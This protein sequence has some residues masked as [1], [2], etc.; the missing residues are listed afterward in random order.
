MNNNDLFL[1]H[2]EYE[3]QNRAF[4]LLS[5]DKARFETKNTEFHQFWSTYFELEKLNQLK[6]KPYAEKYQIKMDAGFS[7]RVKLYFASLSM[8]LFPTFVLNAMTDATIKY[9]EKL[10]TLKELSPPEDSTFFDY[11]IRQERV[12]AEALTLLN[13]GAII[14]AEISIRKFIDANS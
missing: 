13:S 10:E 9:V 3:V 14:E 11:V 6:Y 8:K 5:T 1:N 4:A 12:Q 2:F 7:A